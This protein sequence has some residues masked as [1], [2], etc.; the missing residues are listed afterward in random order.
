MLKVFPNKAELHTK[1]WG[2]VKF[3][4]KFRF[5]FNAKS[6]ILFTLSH[7]DKFKRILDLGFDKRA[8]ILYNI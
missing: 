7:G 1:V 3:Y 2:R 8:F 6:K 4:E 5:D